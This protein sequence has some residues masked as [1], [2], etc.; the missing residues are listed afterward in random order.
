MQMEHRKRKYFRAKILR[1]PPYS[2]VNKSYYYEEDV[3]AY[4]K[5]GANNKLYKQYKDSYGSNIPQEIVEITKD[6]F[7]GDKVTK[8]LPDIPRDMIEKGFKTGIISIEDTCWMFRNLL[9]Y[10]RQCFL[11]CRKR[12]RNTN[13]RSVSGNVF[14]RGD[15]RY[16]L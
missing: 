8:M 4:S 2:F 7:R 9:S 11:F 12:S 6:D 14:D 13:K 16:D 1:I 3:W 10:W 15:N 5:D